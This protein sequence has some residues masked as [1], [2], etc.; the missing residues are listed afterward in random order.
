MPIY[1]YTCKSC[2]KAFEELVRSAEAGDKVICPE[3]GSKKVEKRMSVFAARDAAPAHR[4]SAERCS[5]CPS[6][7]TCQL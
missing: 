5:E 6:R 2:E 1:E 3:C 7:G 4:A